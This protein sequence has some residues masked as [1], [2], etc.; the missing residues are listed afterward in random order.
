MEAPKG[1]STLNLIAITQLQ[2]DASVSLRMARSYAAVRCAI[3]DAFRPTIRASRE[4]RI[5]NLPPIRIKRLNCGFAL[6]ELIAK[7]LTLVSIV[8]TLACVACLSPISYLNA[9]LWGLTFKVAMNY[10]IYQHYP[11]TSF[12]IALYETNDLLT[13]ALATFVTFHIYRAVV[14]EILKTD[15]CRTVGYN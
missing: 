15:Q 3:R 5:E 9:L 2:K 1:V 14:A 6:T 10:M 8:W 12:R 11:G 7:K 4:S 13:I